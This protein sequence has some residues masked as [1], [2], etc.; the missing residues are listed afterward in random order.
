MTR[1]NHPAQ[2]F[3]YSLIILATG[4][5]QQSPKTRVVINEAPP[6]GELTSP[7]KT[8]IIYDTTT[9]PELQTKIFK[10]SGDYAEKL[11]RPTEINSAWDRLISLYSLP[12]IENERIEEQIQWYL[13]YPDYLNLIQKRA[14]LYLHFILDEVEAK[15]I[16]GEFALLPAIESAF[17]PDAFSPSRAAGLWQFIP[18]TGRFFGLAQNRW[19]DG[20]RDIIAST[21]AATRYLKELSEEFDND[22][23]L[24]MASYN[25]GKGNILKAIRSNEEQNIDTD[26]WSLDL[27]R[28]TMNYVP[29]LLA[30]A[31]I[32]AN[33]DQYNLTLQNIPNEPYFE[34]VNLKSQLDLDLAAVMSQM[35]LDDFFMLNPGFKTQSM[36]PDGPHRLLIPVDKADQ[37][38][39]KLTQ[40]KEKD[41]TYWL[42]HRIKP[43]ENLGMIAKKHQTSVEALKQHNHLTGDNIRAGQYLLVPT[44]KPVI[45]PADKSDK[46]IYTVKKGDTFWQIARKFS[47]SSKD[48]ARWNKL[49]LQKPLHPGQKLVIKLAAN[50]DIASDQSRLAKKD[51]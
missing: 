34:V 40:L 5:A 21:R 22:W 46:Q 19:Y 42:R 38:R 32:F 10:E 16:P 28:E 48:I 20:R 35:A 24:A 13:Q 8:Q 45:T 14:K 27:R 39:T 49:T 2:Y 3:I 4:C 31:K 29:R 1:C 23:L 47:V 15:N 25:A 11:L 12:N 36:G 41:R 43:G 17:K 50:T 6:T 9:L 30:I 44:S 33:P 51:G 7:I 26:Y 18:S 37:F